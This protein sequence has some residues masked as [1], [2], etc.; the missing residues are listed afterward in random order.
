MVIDLPTSG[1]LVIVP[2]LRPRSCIVKAFAL[3][4]ERLSGTMMNAL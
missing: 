2:I 4:A 1:D 3:V